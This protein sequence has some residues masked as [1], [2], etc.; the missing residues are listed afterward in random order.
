MVKY[1]KPVFEH[2]ELI[3]DEVVALGCWNCGG[4]SGGS[5]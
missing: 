2:I 5:C 3:P 1:E 4:S